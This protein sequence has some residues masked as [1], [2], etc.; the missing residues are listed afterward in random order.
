MLKSYPLKSA[1][2]FLSE[3]WNGGEDRVGIEWEKCMFVLLDL[4]RVGKLCMCPTK[5]SEKY[6]FTDTLK[7]VGFALSLVNL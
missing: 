7:T 6:N 2:L 1:Q 3:I 5:G 4:N